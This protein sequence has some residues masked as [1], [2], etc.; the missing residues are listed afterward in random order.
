[1]M[2][3]NPDNYR[4]EGIL[5][6]GAESIDAYR[7]LR[8][9][10][11]REHPESFGETPANF[12]AK[13]NRQILE[14]ID[15]QSKLGGFILA[16]TSKLGTLIG[17]VGLAVNDD[18]KSR[19]RA[20][21]WGMYVVPEARNQGVARAL[22][23]ELWVRAGRVSQLEQIHLAVVTTNQA[24]YR[25]YQSMGWM[26]YGTDPSVLKIGDRAFDE[27]LMVKRMSRAAPG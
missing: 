17:T 12:E 7:A 16:A 19:H 22:I 6:V 2:I 10:G 9:R 1:M 14:R 4:Y 8:L 21:L 27:Y 24:A 18:E 5:T 25:V 15:A 3:T 26:T 13:S 20:M 23:E 11:L